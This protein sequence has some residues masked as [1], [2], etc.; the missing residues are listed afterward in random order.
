MS[1]ELYQ[2]DVSDDLYS[3]YRGAGIRRGT[4]RLTVTTV[5]GELYQLDV[6]DDL[7]VENLK[8]FVQAS[9]YTYSIHVTN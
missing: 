8:A 2:L 6:S 1:G 4:M 7:E 3:V 9:T 5:S